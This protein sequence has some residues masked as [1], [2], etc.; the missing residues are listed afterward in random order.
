MSNWWDKA[1]TR[2]V[3]RNKAGAGEAGGSGMLIDAGGMGIGEIGASKMTPALMES[4]VGTS[5]YGASSAGAGGAGGVNWIEV[6]RY[7]QQAGNA[8]QKPVHEIK[9]D[10]VNIPDEGR[11]YWEEAQAGM[12]TSS[13]GAKRPERNAR[14]ADQAMAAG[15]SGADP[16]SQNGVQIA[17]I[18]A[19]TR[20]IAAARQR[21]S[22]IQK[23]GHHGQQ[24]VR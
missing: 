4:A 20:R 6:G 17:A 24:P 8:M 21:L 1:S 2:E 22:A 15:A 14:M 7:L 18:K 12:V 16:I 10:P 19:L 5:G 3:E 23:R 13:R 9:Q 11:P